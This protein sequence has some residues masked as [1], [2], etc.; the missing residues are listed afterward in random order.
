[1]NDYHQGPI[2]P[3]LLAEK[4]AAAARRDDVRMAE[5]LEA[6]PRLGELLRFIQWASFQ[7]GGLAKV[8]G[9]VLAA[10]PDRV[11]TR[12]RPRREKPCGA[13]LGST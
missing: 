2:R 4:F 5:Q 12:A 6:M 10:F 3:E 7:P 13:G 11:L 8:S 9:D 1:M